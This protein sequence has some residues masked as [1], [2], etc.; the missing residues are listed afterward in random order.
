M[1]SSGG[2]LHAPFTVGQTVQ[3]S[4]EGRATVT[5]ITKSRVHLRYADGTNDQLRLSDAAARCAPAPK[6]APKKKRLSLLERQQQLLEAS[7]FSRPKPKP[8]PRRGARGSYVHSAG[9]TARQERHLLRKGLANAARGSR[10]AVP[11]PGEEVDDDEPF[12]N[13]GATMASRVSRAPSLHPSMAGTTISMACSEYTIGAGDDTGYWDFQHRTVEPK[14]L[15]HRC[16]E[17]RQPF[18]HLGGPLT[19]RR[20]ARVS[21]RYHA[22]CFSGYADPRSQAASSHHRGHL[23]GTQFDAAPANKAGSKMRTGSHFTGGG[24]NKSGL[25]RGKGA[26]TGVAAMGAGGRQNDK[27]AA[28]MGNNHFGAAS[29]KGKGVLQQPLGPAGGLTEADLK[30]HDKE[31]GKGK[32]AAMEAF[33]AD[34][35]GDAGPGAGNNAAAEGDGGAAI[36]ELLAN[37]SIKEGKQEGKEAKK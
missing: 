17:C 33:F 22:E 18:R 35:G 25:A 8:K 13:D 36:S 10:V 12:G 16:R 19:E 6:K 2:Q 27:I 21:M 32:N 23:A 34:G 7:G 15:G 5:K 30:Q 26:Y 29:S 31:M 37:A 11:M 28:F 1:A 20:G 14:D 4:G 9:M 3:V 24:G